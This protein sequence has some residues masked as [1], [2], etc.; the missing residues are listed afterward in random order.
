MTIL[1]VMRNGTPEEIAKMIDEQIVND[2]CDMFACDNLDGQDKAKTVLRIH[3]E[4]R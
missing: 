4:N 1:D 3:N 2:V